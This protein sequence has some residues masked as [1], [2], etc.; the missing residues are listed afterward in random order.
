MAYRCARAIFIPGWN[1]CYNPL[2][3]MGLTKTREPTRHPAPQIR[4]I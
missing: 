4:D 1:D 3:E 2:L